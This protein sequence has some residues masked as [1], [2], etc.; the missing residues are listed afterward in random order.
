MH[1]EAITVFQTLGAGRQC[2]GS[3]PLGTE[4]TKTPWRGCY[5]RSDFRAE[6]NLVLGKQRFGSPQ[7]RRND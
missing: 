6:W 2:R 5:V 1:L 4:A 3:E 7:Q